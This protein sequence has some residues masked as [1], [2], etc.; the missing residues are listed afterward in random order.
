MRRRPSTYAVTLLLAS[1]LGPMALAQG[2][3]GG[4]STGG[5][6]VAPAGGSPQP[7]APARSAP[8]LS[9][10]A[11]TGGPVIA[12][13]YPMGTRGWVFPLYPLARVAP[14]RWWSL[15]QGVDVGGNAEQC[16]SRLLELAA[17]SGTIVHEGLDGFGSQ[18]PVLLIESGPDAGRYV[19]YG[20]A[21]PVL[22][23]V[24]AHVGAGQPIAEVGCGIVGVSSSPHLE[25]GMLA[26][27]AKGPEDMPALGQTAHDTLSRLRSAYSAAIAAEKAKKAAARARTARGRIGSG[28]AR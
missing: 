19:Y 12:S 22:V 5:T 25:V 2:A 4:L 6:P 27:S 11:A 20:H 24:G 8:G 14:A 15:D 21:A 3:L 13:P 9:G 16:G 7:G 10:V 23:P 28:H 17:A 26:P 1:L 18:A